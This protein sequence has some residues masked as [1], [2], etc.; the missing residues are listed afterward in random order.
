MV[1]ITT[2][3]VVFGGL[4]GTT[5]ATAM[6]RTL[7]AIFALITPS[8]DSRL[9]QLP[10]SERSMILLAWLQSYVGRFLGPLFAMV[11]Y[12]LFGFRMLSGLGLGLGVILVALTA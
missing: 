7:L 11:M 12:E 3:L 5:L 2:C 9:N 6:L 4:L 1:V 8:N 10:D